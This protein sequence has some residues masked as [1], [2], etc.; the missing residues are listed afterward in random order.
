M[1]IGRANSE[2]MDICCDFDGVIHTFESGWKG[3]NVI[4]DGPTRGAIE[5]LRKMVLHGFRMHIYSSRSREPEGIEL[6]KSW[7]LEQGLPQDI[8]DR[9]SFPTQKPNVFLIIDDRAF[10]FEGDFPSPE[11]ILNFKPWN[12][13]HDRR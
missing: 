9:I 12:R 6:M 11:W 7:L 3:K 8:L 13:W 4:A 2:H 1:K 5:W 10:R